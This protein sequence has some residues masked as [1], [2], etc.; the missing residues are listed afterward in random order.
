MYQERA[1]RVPGAVA[2]SRAAVAPGTSGRVL[3]DGCMD[4]LWWNGELVAAGPDTRAYVTTERRGLPVFGVRLAPGAGPRA[5]GVRAW[6]LCDQRVPLQALWPDRRVRGLRE[7]IAHAADP[8][9]ALE[10]AAAGALAAGEAEA[11]DP[12]AAAL[13]EAVAVLLR[14]GAGV[15]RTAGHVGLSERQLH[16]RCRD[17]F[18][19]GPKTLARVLRLQRALRAAG[20]GLP[21]AETAARAG[22]ADQAHLT[23]EVRALTGL[24]PSKLLR[25]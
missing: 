5:F 21:L 9:A 12:R 18:G 20:S 15:A 23:R 10:Q 1:S 3:P 6:E 7:R 8:L 11:P 17:A 24:T 13:T 14:R 4:L 25:P 19:Y 22:Y 2:W 16:R